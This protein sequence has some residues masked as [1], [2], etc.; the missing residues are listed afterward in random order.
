[1]NK[2]FDFLRMLFRRILL[3]V[4]AEL[5]RSPIEASSI[6]D[7]AKDGGSEVVVM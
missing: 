2:N 1:M 4:R 3:T 5:A 6:D 7:Y